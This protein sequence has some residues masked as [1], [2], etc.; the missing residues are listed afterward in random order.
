MNWYYSINNE[1]FGPVD[2]SSFDELVSRGEVKPE[3]LIWREGMENWATYAAVHSATLSS[4]QPVIPNSAAPAGP[5][6]SRCGRSFAASELV[7][8]GSRFICAGCKPLEVQALSE[9]APT[10]SGAELIRKEHIQHEASVKSVG[11]LYLLGGVLA[12]IFT[13]VALVALTAATGP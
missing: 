4:A 13:V 1:R 9:G 7:Q 10:N 11:F 6:C 12:L 5:S 2:Q 3:T 8:L